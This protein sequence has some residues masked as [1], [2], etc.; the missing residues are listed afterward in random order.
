MHGFY[1]TDG[2]NTDRID[3][4]PSAAVRGAGSRDPLL[5]TM[6]RMQSAPPATLQPSAAKHSSGKGDQEEGQKLQKVGLPLSTSPSLPSPPLGAF[7]L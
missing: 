1:S 7:S 3:V 6:L 5:N 2:M 4:S